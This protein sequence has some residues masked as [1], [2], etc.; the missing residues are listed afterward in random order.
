MALLCHYSVSLVPRQFLLLLMFVVD[1][2]GSFQTNSAVHT[3]DTRNKTKFYRPIAK[4]SR[5]RGV[6]PVSV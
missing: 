6:F 3:T 4:H 2:L 1:N 5:F